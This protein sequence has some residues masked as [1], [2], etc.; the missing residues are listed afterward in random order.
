MHVD[1]YR[2][3]L[4][5]TDDLLA[6]VDAALRLTMVNPAFERACGLS[7][8]Q[9]LGR[10][11]GELGLFGNDGAVLQACFGSA[12]CGG[13]VQ[14]VD[15]SGC[16][17]A[18]EP[19]AARIYQARVMPVRSSD[20][21]ISG[22]LFQAR[23]ITEHRRIEG[24]LREREREFRTLA[25]NSPDNIIRYGLDLRAIYCNREIEE[26]VA[27][28]ARKVLGRTPTES[29]PPGMVGQQ[30]YEQQLL[31]TLASGASGTV[32]LL[33]PHP[34]GEMRVHSVVI[35][36]EHDAEGAI[37]GAL[38]VGR[39]ITSLRRIEDHLRLR[40]RE[41]RTLAE[42][43][44][45]N[46]LR[47]DSEA[48]MRYLNPAMARVLGRPVDELLGFTAPEVYPDG[49]FDAVYAAVLAVARSGEP[50]MLEL[51][52][53]GPDSS[54][55]QVHQVRLFPER[56]DDGQVRSV[57]GVGRDISDS[58]RQR[59][60]IE[61]LARTD[62]LTR[63][64]NRQAL[65]ERAP[66]IFAGAR[67]H[68][69]RV[70][71]MLL[72]LDQFKSVNDALGHSA[73]DALLVEVAR[74]LRGCLR[75]DD[76]L[77]RLGGDEFVIVTPDIEGPDAIATVTTKVQEALAQ[78]LTLAQR[79]VQVTASIG[80]ALYPH[81]GD[82]LDPL[83]AHA[84]S[85]MY[86]AKRSGRART[87]FYRA[88]L[89]EA[90]QRRLLLEQA[91]R[92]ARHGQGLA[93]Y[94]QP[95]VSLAGEAALV[96]AEALLRWQHPRLGLLAPD[97]FIP[98]A[99]ETGMIVP[100]GRWVL[101]TAAETAVQWNRGRAQALCI[102]VNVSSHQFVQDDLPAAVSAVLARTGCAPAW[103]AIEITESALIEDSNLVKQVLDDLRGLGVRVAI[104]DFG[105]GY[106][107]LNYLA[108][109]PVDCLKIDKS[110]VQGIG[111]SSRQSEVV[112]AFIAMARAL[113]LDLVAEGV[114]T[115]DQARFLQ[116]QG[117]PTG[118]G[119]RFGRPMP[120]AQFEAEFL[121]R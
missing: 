52:F 57:L 3:L 112:K 120:A 77:V 72:D 5:Q 88:E 73:G 115:E 109:F 60:L 6:A 59:E 44:G 34:G 4:E 118:Q 106:S 19:R 62:P 67:R 91:L 2:A 98:L 100:M 95:Q 54:G 101:Q 61:S 79:E 32:E 23:D 70:G 37:C 102:A 13:G 75:D 30:A 31:V 45:D 1:P 89:G 50:S 18:G 55:E 28:E 36:A 80:V 92:E 29:A 97:L 46:I 108:R 103:L 87:E 17:E 99:E 56:D 21:V 43:A 66:G 78:P 11:V 104:D 53:A 107:A 111:Q 26:R 9:M 8:A 24:H 93:L 10:T 94:F 41:F 86:H 71:V 114:E 119:Y 76:L 47:W 121:Q 64:D 16:R 96:G 69:R 81:D 48:R 65:R 22:L 51:R 110:F 116:Q 7:A 117:C 35:T 14:R 20:E 39:D 90:V 42:N 15:L 68:H 74:R 82:E 105:T 63:L 27:V 83:L 25:E 49:S 58:I 12:L 38:A 85:A 84:D 40:E 33:A 113:G